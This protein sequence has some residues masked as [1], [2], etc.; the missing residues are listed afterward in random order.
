MKRL[1]LS[2][3]ERG[4]IDT[5]QNKGNGDLYNMIKLAFCDDNAVELNNLRTLLDQ[6]QTERKRELDAAAFQ[7]P[8]ELLAEIERGAR[9][10]ILLLDVI[11][12][13]ET[14]IDAAAE[15][16]NHDT[17]VKIIF[18]T[19]SSEYAVQSYRVG[20]Y[21]YQ[22]KPVRREPFFDLLDSVCR[23]CER[24]QAESLILRCKSGIIR[25]ELREL[26]YCEVLH[27]SL[28]IHLSGGEV[29]ESAGSMDE[30]CR[31]LESYGNFLRVHRS[32]LVNL[33]YVKKLSYRGI[34]LSCAAEIPIPRGKYNEI[35]DAY[36]EHAFQNGKI[37]V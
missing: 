33:E 23:S 7:S 17:C 19:S 21:F 20:A 3:E 11:M 28:F 2:R 5:G 32:Y 4:T 24:E 16:R 1:D 22:L 35:K 10:D 12:P 6:Y 8:F 13:G 36:L 14:G 27:R 26:E 9:F 34:T 31:K 30:F 29:L 18:L 15:I 25:I 37:L